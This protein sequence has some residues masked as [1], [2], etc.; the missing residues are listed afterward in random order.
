[1]LL[2]YCLQFDLISQP[3]YRKLI[4]MGIAALAGTGRIE[5]LQRIPEEIVEL[6]ADVFS[7][8]TDVPPTS[9]I[10]LEPTY[11]LESPPFSHFS[12]YMQ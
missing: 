1:M 5:V 2:T 11:A 3:R 12:R 7:D 6:W 10:T 4:A 8:R 9:T